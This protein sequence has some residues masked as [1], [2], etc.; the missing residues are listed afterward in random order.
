MDN[1]EYKY[2]TAQV[3]LNEKYPTR[4]SEVLFREHEGVL[5]VRVRRTFEAPNGIWRSEKDPQAAGVS[6][7]TY[8]KTLRNKA[9][10]LKEVK[11]NTVIS[12]TDGYGYD[13]EPTADIVITGWTKKLSNSHKIA[14]KMREVTRK[15]GGFNPARDKK[16]A[17][18]DA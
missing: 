17:N 13:D 16:D 14:L 4:L 7:K 9:K 10:G 2:F 6:F 3:A 8:M 12:T 1:I 11:I 18:N 5:E 15:S